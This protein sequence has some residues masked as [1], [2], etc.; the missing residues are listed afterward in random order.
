[1]IYIYIYIYHVTSH[2]NVTT[3]SQIY[4]HL[5]PQYSSCCNNNHS[6]A[7]CA[8]NGWQVRSIKVPKRVNAI[9]NRLNK[10]KVEKHPNLAGMVL[11]LSLSITTH[12]HTHHTHTHTHTAMLSP[13]QLSLSLFSLHSALSYAMLVHKNSYEQHLTEVFDIV[14]VLVIVLL[15][16]KEDRLREQRNEER[17]AKKQKERDQKEERERNIREAEIR[18]YSDLMKQKDAFTSNEKISDSYEDDFM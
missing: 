17:A 13:L 6:Y 18:S 8:I 5:K 7:L 2:W 9:V 15:A 12:T 14:L 1:M 4:Q 3:V 16:Q 10:T 11:D